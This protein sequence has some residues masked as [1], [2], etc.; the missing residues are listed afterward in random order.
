MGTREKDVRVESGTL[1]IQSCPNP[2]TTNKEVAITAASRDRI[3]LNREVAKNIPRSSGNDAGSSNLQDLLA[4]FWLII[5]G[6]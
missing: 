6:V 5:Y 3:V 4:I 2:H 1:L